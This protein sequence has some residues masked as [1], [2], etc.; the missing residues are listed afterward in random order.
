MDFVAGFRGF[1]N[2]AVGQLREK[3]DLVYVPAVKDAADAIRNEKSSPVKQLLNTIA[4]QTIENSEEFREFKE[5]AD[6]TLKNLTSPEN[7][8]QLK[9]ISARLTKILA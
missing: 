2:V 6:E 9:E 5:G 4:R 8:P 7:V 1:K 3:T